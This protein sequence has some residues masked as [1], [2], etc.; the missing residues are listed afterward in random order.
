MTED[1]P[2]NEFPQQVPRK[3]RLTSKGVLYVLLALALSAA[4]VSFMIHLLLLVDREKH[5]WTDLT[6]EGQTIYASEVQL[7][8]IP[9]WNVHYTFAYD[10]KAYSGLALVPKDKQGEMFNYEKSLFPILFLP[11]N[12]SVNHP[13]GWSEGDPAPWHVYTILS[14]L[15]LL[16][17][18]SI[19]Q[20]IFPE[21]QLAR[22]GIVTVGTV[23]G[24][25]IAK[26]G[27]IKLDYE[28]LDLG[29]FRTKGRGYFPIALKDGTEVRVLQMPEKSSQ[30]RPYPLFYFR[31]EVRMEQG[32]GGR[33]RSQ[34]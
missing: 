18:L 19:G 34:G 10:G 2:Q 5:E 21:F 26:N 22:N 14:L 13:K 33:P 25:K 7:R 31:A 17:C 3:V 28:F 8:G 30:N 20:A 15:P 32:S 24:Y 23:T 1:T 6:R 16:F 12:P 29:G 11:S 27:T 4:C 9:E